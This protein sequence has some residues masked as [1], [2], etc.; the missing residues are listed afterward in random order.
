MLARWWSTPCR[1]CTTS[2]QRCV[3]S[4][5]C[6][7]S[8]VLARCAH[9]RRRDHV[10]KRQKLS[11]GFE[12]AMKRI[13]RLCDMDRDNLLSESEITEFQQQ[14]FGVRLGKTE[15]QQLFNVRSP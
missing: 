13:F 14:C 9:F 11:P 2:T 4:L 15:I 5:L 10:T 6:C 1:R 3:S 8:L 12:K 7:V